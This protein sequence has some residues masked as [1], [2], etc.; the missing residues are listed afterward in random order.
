[1]RWLA[2]S[3]VVFATLAHGG[4]RGFQFRTT[5]DT[6]AVAMTQLTMCSDSCGGGLGALDVGPIAAVGATAGARFGLFSFHGG[7]ELQWTWFAR[8]GHSLRAG[9]LLGVSFHIE[10]W[11]VLSLDTKLLF[12]LVGA[13]SGAIGGDLRWGFDLTPDGTH[14]LTASL[15]AL[16]NFGVMFITS[17]GYVLTL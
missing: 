15:G 10:R 14:Q 8:A 1:M 3:G 7:G 5:V 2:L 12:S 4:E 16:W 11:L 13:P 6:G 9:P 17:V